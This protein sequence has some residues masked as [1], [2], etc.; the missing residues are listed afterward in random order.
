MRMQ[1]GFGGNNMSNYLTSKIMV[2]VE[3]GKMSD[4]KL[5]TLLRKIA[6]A[7]KGRSQR[8]VSVFCGDLIA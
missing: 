5:K 6:K 4:A 1:F 2:R 3:H 8:V 7:A